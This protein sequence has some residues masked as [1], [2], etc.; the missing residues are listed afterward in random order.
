[1]HRIFWI[2]FLLPLSVLAQADA[3]IQDFRA[4][5]LDGNV[6]LTWSIKQGYTCNGVDVLRSVDSLNFV[7]IGD[8]E[9]ICG[10]TSA[11]VPY[12][13]TDN[14]P[15]PNAW[16]YYRLSLGG[17]GNSHIISIRIIDIPANN[18]LVVPQPVNSVSQL[19]F[20][21]GAAALCT[22]SVYNVHGSE[23]YTAETNGGVFAIEAS[24]FESG[25]YLFTI[26]FDNAKASI[27]GRLMVQP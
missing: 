10:S 8:I 13:F 6:Y 24:R 25:V 17:L 15:E 20:E 21:N 11:S 12:D 2:L 18:Y 19:Y 16:N 22:L 26:D 3:A 5:E 7:K 23:V 1:M 14:F 27:Q 4:E 9:G